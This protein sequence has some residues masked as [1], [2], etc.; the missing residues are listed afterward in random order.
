M[1]PA[2]MRTVDKVVTKTYMKPLVFI[3]VDNFL[4]SF[5]ASNT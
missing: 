1:P 2:P 3:K 4:K 5:F